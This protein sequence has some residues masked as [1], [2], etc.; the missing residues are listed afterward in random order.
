M[1]YLKKLGIKDIYLIKV[2]RI[3]SKAE[4]REDSNDTD[5]RLIFELEYIDS[6]DNYKDIRPNIY[7]TYRWTALGS[8]L[9]K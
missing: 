3:G 6:L 4:I 1:P 9:D 2:A 7:R 5:P 8:I